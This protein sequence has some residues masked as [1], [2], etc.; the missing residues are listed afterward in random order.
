MKTLHLSGFCFLVQYLKSASL[1]QFSHIHVHR[2]DVCRDEKVRELEA[3]RASFLRKQDRKQS[4]KQSKRDR[5]RAQLPLHEQQ[6]DT[7][8]EVNSNQHSERSAA[9]TVSNGIDSS[10]GHARVDDRVVKVEEDEDA[11][12]YG[13]QSLQT[14][15]EGSERAPTTTS[16]RMPPLSWGGADPCVRLRNGSDPSLGDDHSS[17]EN[18]SDISTS[19]SVS[20][21]E[22]E[23]Y[24]PGDH[25]NDGH[26]DD[27]TDDEQHEALDL[28]LAR[29][30]TSL[31]SPSGNAGDSRE[32]PPTPSTPPPS[33]VAPPPLHVD[34]EPLTNNPEGA[35]AAAADA[36][37]DRLRMPPPPTQTN[38]R[39][40]ADLTGTASTT[41]VTNPLPSS[42]GVSGSNEHYGDAVDTSLE[43]SNHSGQW[44]VSEAVEHHEEP[45]PET[46][47][48]SSSIIAKSGDEDDH[49]P[50]NNDAVLGPPATINANNAVSKA[51]ATDAN[52][53]V[54]DERYLQPQPPPPESLSALAQVA[55]NSPADASTLYLSP[56]PGD[57]TSPPGASYGD[58]GAVEA[59]GRDYEHGNYGDG[60]GSSNGYN[61]GGGG[62]GNGNSATTLESLARQAPG[63]DSHERDTEANLELALEQSFAQAHASLQAS[64]ARMPLSPVTH[65]RGSSTKDDDENDAVSSR[66]FSAFASQNN[67]NYGLAISTISAGSTNSNGNGNTSGNDSRRRSPCR[68]S[69]SSSSSSSSRNGPPLSP[70]GRPLVGALL[71]ARTPPLFPLPP[72][73]ATASAL[74]ARAAHLDAEDDNALND[75]SGHNGI[76]NS[77]IN[78]THNTSSSSSASAWKDSSR[79]SAAASA[80]QRLD[81]KTGEASALQ[82][83]KRV[84]REVG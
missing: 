73:P 83:L 54:F 71:T 56:R 14:Y 53:G 8:A 16:S 27:E 2:D 49:I 52:V 34:S 50:T 31:V 6:Q 13:V 70:G 60:T 15:E 35:S 67:G 10:G 46:S 33:A 5:Q 78:S 18:D 36:A 32:G 45:L 28:P 47:F 69:S 64:A 41:T 21:E 12:R 4:R 84:K 9:A 26:D 24:L 75:S 37:A 39:N 79:A 3:E 80:I 65:A 42:G 44:D 63:T 40:A 1:T 30:L 48:G 72:S 82:V 22:A 62:N 74:A 81:T 38:R 17:S 76:G 58:G 11:S 19:T 55:P 7:I 29:S 43:E 25:S 57:L 66:A 77:S 20:D 68:S 59:P 61:D 51:N 23:R